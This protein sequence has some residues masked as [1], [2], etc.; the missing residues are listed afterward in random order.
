MSSSLTKISVSGRNDLTNSSSRIATNNFKKTNTSLQE[1]I[2]ALR[3]S[4]QENTNISLRNTL[5]TSNLN[6]LT[7][8]SQRAINKTILG[9][10]NDIVKTSEALT[11]NNN[12]NTISSKA[13]SDFVLNNLFRDNTLFSNVLLVRA[14][15]YSEL[16]IDSLILSLTSKNAN[17]FIGDE[18]IRLNL[19]RAINKLSERNYTAVLLEKTFETDIESLRNLMKSDGNNST[20]LIPVIIDIGF[21]DSNQVIVARYR[22]QEELLYLDQQFRIGAYL[23]SDVV[24][25]STSDLLFNSTGDGNLPEFSRINEQGKTDNISSFKGIINQNVLYVSEF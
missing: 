23:N 18:V 3:R 7:K 8:D 24:N 2:T 25:Q 11:V 9:N 6:E 12:L 4:V 5:V 15:E 22:K 14:L 10:T 19:S 20:A 16:L 21:L 17:E 13:V 1:V